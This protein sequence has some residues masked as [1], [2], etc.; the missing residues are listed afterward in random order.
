MKSARPAYLVPVFV[1]IAVLVLGQVVYAG[2]L[3]ADWGTFLACTPA[4]VAT[5]GI[6]GGMLCGMLFFEADEGETPA[7]AAR[8]DGTAIFH[9]IA[10]LVH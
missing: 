8:P 10:R 9:W 6:V 3:T 7:E 1:I 5:I 2:L 4:I